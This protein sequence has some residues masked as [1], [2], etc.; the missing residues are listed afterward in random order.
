MAGLVTLFV[1]LVVLLSC[2]DATPHHYRNFFPGARQRF[3]N[4]YGFGGRVTR[5]RAFESSRNVPTSNGEARAIYFMSNDQENTIVAL[6][7]T[8]EGLLAEGTFTSTGGSGANGIDGETMEPA[9]PDALFSQG[10]ITIAGDV[11]NLC[12]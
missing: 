7:V 9:V 10:A 5:E 12:F 4:E 1:T 6:P 11:S 3:R 8:G 2:V